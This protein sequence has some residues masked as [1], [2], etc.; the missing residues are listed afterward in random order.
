MR[1][2]LTKKQGMIFY[3][4][5]CEIKDFKRAPTLREIAQVFEF[6][7]HYAAVCHLRAIERKGYIRLI[8]GIHRGIEIL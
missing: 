4:I 8:P 1:K 3:F 7:A 2:R 5:K 6:K